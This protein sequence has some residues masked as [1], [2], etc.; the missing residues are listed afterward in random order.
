MEWRDRSGREK[1]AAKPPQ[2]KSVAWVSDPGKSLEP[3]TND[4]QDEEGKS[5]GLLLL[6]LQ[7]MKHK[8]SYP[9][10]RMPPVN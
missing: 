10:T 6:S 8:M 9:A 2:S 3:D 7:I 4:L 5:S 1:K